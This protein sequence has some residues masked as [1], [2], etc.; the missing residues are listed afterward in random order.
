[1][2]RSKKEKVIPI[3]KYPQ[4]V[5]NQKRAETRKVSVGAAAV[6]D[7]ERKR[8]CLKCKSPDH[9]VF[10]CPDADTDEAKKLWKAFKSTWK[11][12]SNIGGIANGTTLRGD[13]SSDSTFV[14][15]QC[16]G[17]HLLVTTDY[18]AEESVISGSVAKKLVENGKDCREE[19]LKTRAMEVGFSGDSVKIRKEVILTLKMETKIGPLLLQNVNCW[20]LPRDLPDGMG[21]ILLSRKVMTKLGYSPQKLLAN[22]RQK[23]SRLDVTYSNWLNGSPF[24]SFTVGK[25]STKSTTEEFSEPPTSDLIGFEND[26]DPKYTPEWSLDRKE[27]KT[28]VKKVL[29]EKVEE[30]R[31]AGCSNE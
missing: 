17:Q 19:T 31:K 30:A 16:G 21:D 28:K 5:K 9:T 10:N 6:A 4:L 24:V 13:P 2:A 14:S 26:M 20:V 22:A 27:E 11:K 18:G 3:Q 25:I 15:A 23:C 29:K 12:K 8:E 1:M 7:G